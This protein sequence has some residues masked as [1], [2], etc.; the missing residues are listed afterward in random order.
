MLRDYDDYAKYIEFMESYEN[1][2]YVLCKESPEE[3]A[4]IKSKLIN[5]QYDVESYDRIYL[6]AMEATEFSAKIMDDRDYIE[7]H[8]LLKELDEIEIYD[9]EYDE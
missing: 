3:W 1:Q 7:N 6:A 5:K 8:P 9:D 2:L 4:E